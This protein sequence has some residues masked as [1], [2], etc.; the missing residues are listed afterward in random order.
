VQ[1]LHLVR[2]VFPLLDTDDFLDLNHYDMSYQL[3]RHYYEAGI[4]SMEDRIIIT[5][6][7]NVMTE[8]GT[9]LLEIYAVSDIITDI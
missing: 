1:F 7:S 9:N 3:I 4:L 5:S 6:G 8:R 2:G